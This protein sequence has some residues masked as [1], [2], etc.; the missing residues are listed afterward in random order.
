M[1]ISLKSCFNGYLNGKE[2]EDLLEVKVEDK[3]EEEEE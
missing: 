2:D 1:V 3:V